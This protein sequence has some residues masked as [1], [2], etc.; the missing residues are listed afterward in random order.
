MRKFRALIVDDNTENSHILRVLL[1][2]HGYEVEEACHGASALAIARDR[3]PDIVISDILM[4]VMDGFVFCH[5]WK[6]NKRFKNVPFVFYSATYTDERDQAFALSL[7]ADRFIVKPEKTDLFLEIVAEMVRAVEDESG[8]RAEEDG[9]T[10][11]PEADGPSALTFF[12][13]YSE[14]LLRKLDAKLDRLNEVSDQQRKGQAIQKR[15]V[16][17]LHQ[18]HDF[19]RTVLNI[20]PGIF[21]CCDETL[22]LFRWNRNL[23]RVTGYCSEEIARMKVLDFLVDADQDRLAA[24]IHGSFHKEAF[25][26]EMEL[27]MKDG[28]RV[29]YYI[30]GVGAEIDGMRC[31]IY[32]GIDM[33]A[34]R[35]AHLQ[36]QTQ[37]EELRRWNKALLNREARNLEL[38]REVNDL[39]AK[40]GQP[41]RYPSVFSEVVDLS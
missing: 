11:V 36:V 14:T 37:M 27:V 35:Q 6:T 19:T 22:R 28:T 15:I 16:T 24:K 40:I 10:F 26:T 38:K 34:S 21:G 39:L 30:T 1:Q 31:L 33:S 4:P 41:A 13:R 7:G 23:E 12:Q 17:E 20:L 18:E 5:E 25:D 8:A 2:K 9:N 29:P 32:I 3:L